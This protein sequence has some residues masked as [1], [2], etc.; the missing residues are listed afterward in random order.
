[1][2]II[3]MHKQ[4]GREENWYFRLSFHWHNIICTEKI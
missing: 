1:M 4:T 3:V 2:Y